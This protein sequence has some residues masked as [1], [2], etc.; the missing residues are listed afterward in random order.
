MILPDCLLLPPWTITGAGKVFELLS[1]CAVFGRRGVLV[2]GRSL[3]KKGISARLLRNVTGDMEVISWEH[4]GGE[5]TLK[6]LSELMKAAKSHKAQWIAGV[7]GGSVMDLAKACAGLFDTEREPAFYHDGGA[8]ECV[9]IPLVA[10]PTTAGTGAEATPNAVLTNPVTELKKSIRN[11]NWVSRLIILDPDLIKGC[12]REVIAYSGMDAFTQAVESYTSRRATWASDVFAMKGIKLIAGSLESVYENGGEESNENMNLLLGSYFAGIG[13]SI[14]RLG[15]VHGLAHP[16]GVRSHL[17]HG[18]VCAVCLPHVIE[19]N[20]CTA[21]GKYDQI[22]GMLGNELLSYVCRLT[23]KFSIDS[24]LRDLEIKDMNNA[25][26]ETLVSGS[27]AANPRSVTRD[28]VFRMIN[29]IMG[30]VN[31]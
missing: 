13:L 29:R 25:I 22:S 24:T 18:L 1:S 21:K 20:Y 12:P 31:G 9:G 11:D 8:I 3:R 6:H 4:T 30:N 17:P 7:G 10:V 14:A 26:E 19:F 28:D 15:L 27:T 5:P 23:K 16:L 2:H